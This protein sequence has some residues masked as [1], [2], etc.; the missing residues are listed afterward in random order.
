MYHQ[1]LIVRREDCD[2]FETVKD[3]IK[4]FSDGVSLVLAAFLELLDN[5][6]RNVKRGSK[7]NN[8]ARSEAMCVEVGESDRHN[9][10]L[11]SGGGA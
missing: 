2:G 1:R 5:I 10:D 3:E 6:F 11:Q 4:H 7:F 9:G 8:S